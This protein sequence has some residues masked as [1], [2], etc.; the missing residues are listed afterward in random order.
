M[1]RQNSEIDKFLISREDI[2]ISKSEIFN[3][4]PNIPKE[5]I[6]KR[7]NELEAE[8]KI[9]IG[10]KGI[11]WIYSNEKKLNKMLCNCLEV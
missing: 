10:S 1:I 9:I 11:Q 7:L 4:L 2:P 6:T 5:N 3:R 8:N